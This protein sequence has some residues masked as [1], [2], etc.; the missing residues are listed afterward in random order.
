MEKLNSAILSVLASGLDPSVIKAALVNDIKPSDIEV[1]VVV[2]KM[3]DAKISGTIFTKDHILND[4]NM[5]RIEVTRGLGDQIVDGTA[6][7]SQ[8]ALVNKTIGEVEFIK[9]GS[10]TYDILSKE[11]IVRLAKV[12]ILVE[13][14]LKEGPQDIEW[15]VEKGT[16]MFYLLQT[17]QLV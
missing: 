2:Q 6:K 7:E 13:D 3:I 17:R 11:E 10:K 8:H 16:D 14:A 1:A 12:G 4:E 15:G 5:I 9:D